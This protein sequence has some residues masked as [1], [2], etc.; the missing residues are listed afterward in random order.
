[1]IVDIKVV[2][3]SC[4]KGIQ[5]S[6]DNG[7]SY[8]I[9]DILPRYATEG[10]VG[11]DLKGLELKEIYSGTK[12]VHPNIIKS[13]NERRFF[14][15]REGERALVGTGLFVAIPDGYELQIR[16]RS[17]MALKKGITILNSPG[18]IDQDY[19]GEIGLI[20][21][22][23]TKFNLKINLEDKLAQGVLCPVAK[24]TQWNVVEKLEETKRDTGGFGHTK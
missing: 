8:G 19:R 10:S 12:E 15:L 3:P 16:P 9:N 7:G 2:I 22:N 13:A 6:I 18:T 23:T 17:G 1:M 4:C 14:T 24:L 5:Q 20:L 21:I 11:L